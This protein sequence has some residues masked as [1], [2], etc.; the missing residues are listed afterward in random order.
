MLQMLYELQQMLGEISGLPAVS[1][2]PAAGAQGELTALLVA[3][4]YFRDRGETRTRVLIPGERPRHQSR[5]CR[6][7]R[8]RVRAAQGEQ[9]RTGRS[10]RAEDAARREDGRVH[11]HQPEYSGPLR[12][13]DHADRQDVARRRRP[14]LYRRRQHERHPGHHAAGRLR[15]RHD[16]LQRPQDIHRAARSRRSGCRADR[17][18]RLPG[19]VSSWTGRLGLG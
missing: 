13:P 1:L 8:L 4:A 2:Q 18:P 17:R 7:G 10:R 14:G 19:P 11:D 16:A 9:N 5:E 12:D 3:A 15:R 6:P